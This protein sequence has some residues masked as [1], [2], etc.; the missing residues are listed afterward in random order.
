MLHVAVHSGYIDF[1]TTVD[2]R[3][4]YMCRVKFYQRLKK[5]RGRRK[6]KMKEIEM[7][8]KLSPSRR[9]EII[10]ALKLHKLL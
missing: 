7:I 10:I 2:A 9:L 4:A 3:F 8:K 5:E 1:P 6:W